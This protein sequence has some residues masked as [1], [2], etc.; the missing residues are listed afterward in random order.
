MRR[1]LILILLLLAWGTGCAKYN[2]HMGRV[3]SA[4]APSPLA[5]D[6]QLQMRAVTY[7]SA[8][9]N[10]VPE[11]VEPVTRTV[12]IKGYRRRAGEYVGDY[13]LTLVYTQADFFMEA[14][15]PQ[16]AIPHAVQIDPGESNRS[17]VSD[18]AKDVSL[19]KVSAAQVTGQTRL[20][21]P[22]ASHLDEMMEAMRPKT[23][24]QQ[25]SSGPDA[26]QDAPP[27]GPLSGVTGPPT[28]H[29]PRQPQ[30]PLPVMDVFD[31]RQDVHPKEAP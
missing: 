15:R 28:L 11:L 5:D 8:P 29:P 6:H 16:P 12:W 3:G 18:G 2:T 27:S 23:G 13:P 21:P 14:A 26:T 30:V 25:G 22:Q 31:T 24:P 4:T 1:S 9:S 17:S 7:G 19:P 20:S 10:R